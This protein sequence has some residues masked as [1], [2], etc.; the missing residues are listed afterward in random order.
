MSGFFFRPVDLSA[1]A[2]FTVAALKIL[3]LRGLRPRTSALRWLMAGMTGIAL[4]ALSSIVMESRL[5]GWAYIFTHIR[6]VFT[7]SIVV[8]LTQYIYHTGPEELRKRESQYALLAGLGAQTYITLHS[9]YYMLQ[10]SPQGTTALDLV[11]SRLLIGAMLLWTLFLAT[12]QLHL[13]RPPS[14]FQIALL[15]GLSLILVANLVS[16]VDFDLTYSNI[17]QILPTFLVSVAIILLSFFYYADRDLHSTQINRLVS[18]A[19][20]LLQSVFTILA[21]VLTMQLG[22]EV[23]PQV[24]YGQSS[25]VLS[26][27]SSG[28]QLEV[29][30]AESWQP[31]G[32]PLDGQESIL[33]T[34]FPLIFF[35]EDYSSLM[36]RKGSLLFGDRWRVQKARYFLQAFIPVIDPI[37]APEPDLQIYVAQNADSLVISWMLD[38]GRGAQWSIDPEGQMWLRYQG[39]DEVYLNRWGLSSGQGLENAKILL[40]YPPTSDTTVPAAGIYFRRSYEKRMA[41][42]TWIRPILFFQV[43]TSLLVGFALWF[44]QNSI[45]SQ[46]RKALHQGLSQ[47]QLEIAALIAA[48]KSN[49]EIAA[50]LHITE[51]T[52]KYHLVHINRMLGLTDRKGLAD[53]YREKTLN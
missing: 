29:Q 45:R 27:S 19:M 24:A 44:T 38:D 39:L 10:F 8:A 14:N 34:D 16:V 12:R 50:E 32:S 23:G 4:F 7:A 36:V 18:A 9:V 21:V 3:H 20:L 53:W 48:G 28:Y 35:G 22:P 42:N 47:R 37:T 26:P 1:L 17:E 33:S 40:S 2:L 25:Y 6:I 11:P 46:N 5:D 43:V 31:M 13:S 52:V 49:I 51:S 41:L 30:A 15:I